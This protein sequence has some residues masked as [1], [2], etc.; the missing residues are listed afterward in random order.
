MC[1]SDK[2]RP[3]LYAFGAANKREKKRRLD[4]AVAGTSKSQSCFETTTAG[5]DETF[6]GNPA[7]SNGDAFDVTPPVPVPE[8]EAAAQPPTAEPARGPVVQALYLM[9]DNP[10]DR[11]VFQLVFITIHAAQ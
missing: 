5:E 2:P 8:N 6:E 1:P 11:A 4:N 3:C 9:L 7:N 10:T